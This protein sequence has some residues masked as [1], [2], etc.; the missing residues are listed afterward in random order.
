MT[1]IESLKLVWLIQFLAGAA[2][3]LLYY[4]DFMEEVRDNSN[5]DLIPEPVLKGFLFLFAVFGG[6]YFAYIWWVDYL[7]YYFPFWLRHPR[8]W[9]WWEVQR[10]VVEKYRNLKAWNYRRKRTR[11]KAA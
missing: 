6:W 5:F 8:A 1:F 10:P 4:K 11:K 7:Q 9:F 2:F 3:V